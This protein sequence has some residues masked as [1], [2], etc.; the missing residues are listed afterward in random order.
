MDNT[1]YD[2]SPTSGLGPPTGSFPLRVQ[3]GDCRKML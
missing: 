2:Q 3:P 1:R